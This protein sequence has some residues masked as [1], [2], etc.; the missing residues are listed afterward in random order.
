MLEGQREIPAGYLSVAVGD[1]VTYTTSLRQEVPALVTA[2]HPRKQ[3][4]QAWPEGTPYE[5]I[6]D[7]APLVNLVFVSL[8]ES[9]RD[10]WGRQTEKDSSV[11]PDTEA[12]GYGKSWKPRS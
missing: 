1:V 9:R 2:L 4:H 11:H 5:A 3:A 10:S 8:D 12:Q 6:P 7:D